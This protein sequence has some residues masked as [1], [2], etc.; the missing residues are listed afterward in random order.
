[1]FRLFNRKLFLSRG[2]KIDPRAFVS[3]GGKVE[4]GM[5]SIVRAG[6]MLLP[7]G[8]RILI[9]DRTSLNQYVVVNGEGGVR[10]GDDVMISAFV[11]IFAA[12]HHYVRADMPIRS[13]G[14]YTKGGIDIGNDVWIGTHAVILDGVKIG[15]GCVVAAGA[16]VTRDTEPYSIVAGVPAKQIGCRKFS[17]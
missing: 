6:T 14:M 9:G 2:A 3:R 13:Q 15:A 17:S 11:S 4:I 1:M 16:V 7:S 12:N 8:G 10:I 5:D